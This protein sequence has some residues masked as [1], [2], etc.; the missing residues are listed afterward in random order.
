MNIAI[1]HNVVSSDDSPEDQDTM[2]Q[3]RA[4]SASLCRLGHHSATMPCTLDLAALRE[5]LL[6]S[7]PQLVFNLIESLGGTD[8]LSYLALAV[9]DAAPR[10]PYTGNS[11]EALF[12]TGSKLL[13]K[14]MMQ[15]AGLPTPPWF[16]E[17]GNGSG[18]TT[19]SLKRAAASLNL[20]GNMDRVDWTTTT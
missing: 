7:R 3:V 10:L 5:E 13:A 14:R 11:T 16:A 15:L 8:S 20:Y 2:T 6:E 18:S 9:M 19:L 17:D 1:L 4:V 12:T